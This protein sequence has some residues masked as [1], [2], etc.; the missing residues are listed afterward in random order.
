[1]LSLLLYDVSK[2]Q[3]ICDSFMRSIFTPSINHAVSG[4]P[5]A[6]ARQEGHCLNGD[7]API[8]KQQPLLTLAGALL[9]FGIH[10][11]IG[12]GMT[13]CMVAHLARNSMQ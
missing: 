11:Q 2:H 4:H 13:M 1:M 12:L 10:R 3:R 9:V 7:G 5:K 8:F 6:A